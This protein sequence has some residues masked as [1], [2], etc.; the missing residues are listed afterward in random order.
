MKSILTTVALTLAL[1]GL[2]SI[3]K[4]QDHLKVYAGFSNAS[5][6]LTGGSTQG[7]GVAAQYAVYTYEKV[8]VEATGDFSVHTHNVDPNVYQYLAGPQVSIEAFEHF[9]PFARVLFGTTR[10]GN[11]GLY[12][13]G[14]GIGA[15]VNIGKRYGF[16]LGGDRLTV[17]TIPFN[18]N[19]VNVGA[20]VRF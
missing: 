19:R 17:S 6:Q 7:I 2:H 9:T 18:V 16:R 4:A 13:H 12:T 14:I 20:F 5:S 10:Q 1:M 11:A 3:G 8:S 15:D